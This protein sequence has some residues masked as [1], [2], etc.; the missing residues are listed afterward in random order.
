L[1]DILVRLQAA[2][3][4]R[5]NL[6]RELGRGGMATVYLARDLKHE[7]PVAIKVL[8]PELGMALGPERF[9]REIRYAARLQHPHILTLLDSGECAGLLWY[10]MPYVE[11]ES[12]RDRLQREVQL[13]LDDSLRIAYQVAQ[14]LGYAHEHGVIHRD[15]KPENI[16]LA[17]NGTLVADFGIA[18]AL[19]APGIERLTETGLS[20]GTPAYMSPEQTADSRQLDGRSDLY[21]LG[22]VVYEMLA[23]QPPFTGPTAQSILARHAVDPVPSLRTIRPTVPR[24]VETAIMKAMAKVP[25]DRYA[26]MAQ[27]AEALTRAEPARTPNRRLPA[28]ILGGLI[29]T[30]AVLALLAGSDLGGLL[31]GLRGEPAV[32]RIR[33]LA[34]LPLESLSSDSSQEYLAVGMTDELITN[35][36]QLGALRVIARTSVMRY[37]GSKKTLPEIAHELHVDAL[38]AGTVQRVGDRVRVGAQLIPAV[39]DQAVWANSYAGDVRDILALQSRVAQAIAQQIRVAVTPAERVRL[40]TV[41]Q[42]DPRAYEAYVRGRYFLGKRTKADFQRAVDYFMGA[43]NA[44]PTYAAAYSGLADSYNMLGYYTVLA[45]KEAYPKALSAARKALELD[46]TLAD[47]HASLAWALQMFTWDWPV[48]GREYRRAIEL[49]PGYVTGHAWYGTYLAAMGQHDQAIAEGKRAQ[50]LDPLSLIT[51]AA[52]ARPFYNARRYD[53]A[54]AQSKKTFEIDPRYHRAFYWLGLAYEQKS[55]FDQAVAA[56]HQAIIYSDSVP[57]YVAAA[58]HAYAA[59]GRRPQALKVLQRLEALSSKSYV[60][61]FDIALIHLGLG[62]MDRAVEW[63]ERAYQERSDGLVF[64]NV[65][66]RLDRLR[67]DPRFGSLVRRVGLPL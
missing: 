31:R 6:E 54:I 55:M 43:I 35:L 32:S 57:L 23:G 45:P 36:A 42:V 16:L 50:E 61:A 62:D 47:A 13:D 2:L 34:V 12:L 49:N 27:F 37:K 26:G 52:L 58:G 20:L 24:G 40:T 63:L 30:A 3:A 25:A 59:A 11:G 22:C 18:K 33:S 29:L 44:D 38:V 9:L 65:D 5:Y 8:H 67:L 19:E 10:T 48:A 41:R 4:D 28:M 53:E 7:R 51:S 66:P 14:A 60:S 1:S 56:F 15:V 17:K 39:G 46:S 64:L 21:A